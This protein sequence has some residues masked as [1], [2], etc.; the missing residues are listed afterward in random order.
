MGCARVGGVLNESRAA[1]EV[2]S[3]VVVLIDTL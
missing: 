2:W 1:I 3:V